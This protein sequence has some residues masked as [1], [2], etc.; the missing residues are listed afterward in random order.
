MSIL[1]CGA[2]S[3]VGRD[4]CDLLDREN[5]RYDG[6]YFRCRERES[7]SEPVAFCDRDNMFQVDFTNQEEVSAFF[8]AN[9]IEWRVCVFLVGERNIETCQR[10]WETAIRINVDTVDYMS[11]L[12]AKEGIY[13]IHLST[14][15]VFDGTIQPSFP[16]SIVNP[17]QNYG[18]S[19]LLSELRVQRN[20]TKAITLASC[21][22]SFGCSAP[23]YCIIR[24]PTLYT[25]RASSPLYTNPLMKLAR[26]IMDLREEGSCVGVDNREVQRPLYIPDLC[27]F[28]R[29]IAMVAIDS[30]TGV[31]SIQSSSGTNP[32]KFSGIY[33]FY[34]PDNCLTKYEITK[35]V[36]GYMG[37]SCFHV[38]G[39][40]ET[41]EQTK[42]IPHDPQLFDTRF[43]I[44][45]YFTHTFD[46]TIPHVF[47]RF[48]H[49]KLGSS[50]GGGG[51]PNYFILFDLDGTLVHTSYAHYRSYLEVFRNRGLSFMSYTQWKTYICYKNVHTFLEEVAAH[52][53]EN[54]FIQTERILSEIRNEKLEAFKIYAPLY[55]TPTKNAVDMLRWIEKHPDTTNAVIVANCSQ[56]TADIICS[57][58]PELKMITN[59]CL[60]ENDWTESASTTANPKK[61]IY[62]RAKSMYYNQE[63][64]IIGFENT[65]VGY[66][67][68]TKITPVVYYYIDENE[69]SS[70]DSE[71]ID[72]FLFNDYRSVYKTNAQRNQVKTKAIQ[73]REFQYIV[74]KPDGSQV[75][76][77]YLLDQ[78]TNDVY[79]EKEKGKPPIRIGMLVGNK[80]VET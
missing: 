51:T 34:N 72:A 52:I 21:L 59:W 61:D 17:I 49:P 26:H 50:G 48:N 60:R 39:A 62:H 24:T 33:H 58:V 78:D 16:T 57:V 7:A 66:Q 43:N 80:V 67:S 23:H 29:V 65:Y 56:E 77:R 2:S 40:S 69:T 14:D 6:T 44:R 70:Y 5:I 47:S 32:P 31:S 68:I 27:V 45:N 13:F 28:I 4:L 79:E 37:L 42:L 35:A 1:I 73:R 53:A 25:S 55:V 46:E 64:Y 22:S 8:T 10:N 15:Y 12:C 38:V 54:D 36:A 75:V 63:Q 20:Y 30:M 9:K 71:R 76:K 74:V 11:S 18:M 19:K 41:T 3:S